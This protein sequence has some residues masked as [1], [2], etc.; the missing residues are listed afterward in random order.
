M[1][2]PAAPRPGRWT[3]LGAALHHSARILLLPWPRY[4]FD[5][6]AAVQDCLDGPA[7]SRAARALRDD[8]DGRRVLRVSPR[9]GIPS[10]D[11]P[12]LSALPID[13]LGYNL[14]HHFHS[15]GLLEEV[16]LGPPVVCWDADTECAKD[17][18]RATHDL[19]HVLLGLGVSG[20]EEVA[21]QAFQCAQ[22]FQKLSALIVVFGAL[23]HS[24]ADGAGGWLL[25]TLPR[26]W[27]AGRR[28]RFV[29]TMPVEQM[30]EMRLVDARAAWGV[31]PVGAVYPVAARHPDARPLA[32]GGAVGPLSALAG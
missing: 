25:R 2:S 3:R 10:V 13:S 15:N 14:W 4:T 27:R 23:K 7:F 12:A 30:W 32:P 18:Y 11:W 29:L 21:L 20:P 17:R 8:D 24:L 22:L 5:D 16:P 9:L 19:R 26:A 31:V 28:A 6:L 1:A